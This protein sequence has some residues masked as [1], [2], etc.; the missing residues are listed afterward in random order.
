M[1]LEGVGLATVAELPA[2]GRP[3]TACPRLAQ[4]SS[5]DA[6]TASATIKRRSN[7]ASS[8]SSCRFMIDPASS[9]TAGICAL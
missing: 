4:N 2:G 9:S 5:T 3:A 7:V 6:V 8:S 1:L